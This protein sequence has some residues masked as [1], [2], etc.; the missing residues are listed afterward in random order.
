MNF[1][2]LLALLN[3]TMYV[4]GGQGGGGGDDPTPDNG[5]GGDTPAPNDDGAGGTRDGSNPDDGT[6]APDDLILG[7]FKDAEALAN[8]YKNLESRFGSFVG[9][10]KDGVYQP[11]EGFEEGTTPEQNRLMAALQ[12]FGKEAQLSQDGYEKLFK[13]ITSIQ[14]R[15]YEEQMKEEIAKIPNYET[16]VQAVKDT[17]LRVLRPDQLEALD[18]VMTTAESFEAVESV[19]SALKGGSLP[20][21]TNPAVRDVSEVRKELNELNPADTVNRKRLLDEINKLVGDGEGRL[22]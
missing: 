5:D 17:A 2:K 8:S 3:L 22:V 12:E 14:E 11:I 1:F 13:D 21:N 19:I 16:R 20:T 6:P 10:P 18:K 15:Q 7:K 4:D 9:A